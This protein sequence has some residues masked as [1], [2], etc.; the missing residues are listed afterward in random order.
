MRLLA[1]GFGYNLARTFSGC[2]GKAFGNQEIPCITVLHGYDVVFGAQAL[3][4]L[5]ENH[6]HV[7]VDWVA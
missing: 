2:N 7:A 6:V 5:F 3:N 1:N 4:V